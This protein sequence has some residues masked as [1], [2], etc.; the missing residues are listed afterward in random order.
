[1][2]SGQV[3][4]EIGSDLMEVSNKI[5]LKKA[6]TRSCLVGSEQKCSS[7]ED[8]S[9]MSPQEDEALEVHMEA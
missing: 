3:V 7:W 2:V 5:N 4:G 6:K 9:E 1:M 8:S